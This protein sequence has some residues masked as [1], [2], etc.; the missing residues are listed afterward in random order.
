M[1]HK[2]LNMWKFG[3][4]GTLKEV[5]CHNES[6]MLLVLRTGLNHD[7]VVCLSDICCCVNPLSC[8]ILSSFELNGKGRCMELVK[9]GG[10]CD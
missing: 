2:R 5:L 4:K 10:V 7:G 8:S 3:L 6:R 9:F 1:A